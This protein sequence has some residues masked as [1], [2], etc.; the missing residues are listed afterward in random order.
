M[1]GVLVTAP[2]DEIARIAAAIERAATPLGVLGGP[3][4]AL[5][6]ELFAVCQEVND[7]IDGMAALLMEANS[8][9]GFDDEDL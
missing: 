3:L 1:A 8:R 9:D 4:M 6:M 7:A 2:G 5:A